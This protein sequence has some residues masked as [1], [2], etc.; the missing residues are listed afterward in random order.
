MAAGAIEYIPVGRER[1]ACLLTTSQGDRLYIEGEPGDETPVAEGD[2]NLVTNPAILRNAW[3]FAE[4]EFQYRRLRNEEKR[5]SHRKESE[6]AKKSALWIASLTTHPAG[7]E[8]VAWCSACLHRT[9]HRKAKRVPGPP[10]FLCLR[11]GSPTTPCFAPRCDNMANR[12]TGFKVLSRYCAEH[13]HDIPGFAKAGSRLTTIDDYRE[14][15]EF[16]KVNLKR[17]SRIVALGVG[18]AAI[19]TPGAFVAAPVIG[20]VIGGSFIGGGLSG[21]AAVSH[22]L[23]LLGGGSLAAGGFGM[24]GGT[25]VVAV[26]GAA[27]GTAL[28]GQLAVTYASSDS[29]FAIE[30]LRD[31][32]GPPVLLASGFLT[33]G[34]TGWGTWQSLIDERYPKSPVYRVFWGAKE[35]KSFGVLGADLAGKTAAS[36]AVKSLAQRGIRGANIPGLNG[37]LLAHG[38]ARNP[39]SVAKS[40][41][42]M[43]G[44][45]LAVLLARTDTPE[46]VLVG[47]SLGARVMARTAQLLGSD[48]TLK[49]P[50]LREAHLLACALSTGGDWRTLDESA[51]RNV[52]NYRSRNDWVLNYLYKYAQ[53]GHP[54]VGVKGFGSKH[55][56]I[57]DR[58]VSR[59]VHSHSDYF[60]SVHLVGN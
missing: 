46:F 25:A 41:A 2:E 52:W 48:D 18:G 47:H 8:V 57:K 31:G 44:A 33:E 30:K 5:Q 49:R 32:S 1:C 21:A 42:D 20:G 43:T 10:T 59:S 6:E 3:A 53:L 13:R 17:A 34:D 14:W 38:V 50:K 55:A 45:V 54:A 24:A 35:L 11:C 4:N 27:L 37:L 12:G 51:S 22:G 7:K 36:Q 9:N 26:A 58:D 19:V 23:A 28:G 15:L 29:S 40:R 16:D 56:H 60:N 39:W